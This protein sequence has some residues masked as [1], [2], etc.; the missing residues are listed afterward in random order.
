MAIK[1]MKETDNSEVSKEEFLKKVVM[2][3]KF[4]CEYIIH[5]YRAS[6]IQNKICLVL[7]YAEYR[8]LNVVIKRVKENPLS[9]KMRVKIL[10]DSAL[11]LEYLHSNEILHCDINLDKILIVILKE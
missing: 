2:L 5:F 8:S 7:E 10:L 11:G 3:D 9:K 6:F 4:L 1:I